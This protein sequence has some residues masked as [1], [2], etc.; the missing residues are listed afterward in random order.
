MRSRELGEIEMRRRPGSEQ[1]FNLIEII[2]ALAVVA[3]AIAIAFPMFNSAPQNLGAD[4]QDFSL[5]V[6]VARE[7]GTSR[8]EHYRVRVFSGAPYQYAIEGCTNFNGTNCIAWA[9][10]RVI[11]LRPN[12]AFDAGTL[13][14]VAEF[15]TRGMLVTTPPVTFTLQDTARG[16][17][18]QVT[19]N[20]V[21]MVDRP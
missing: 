11:G 1:G 3:A 21:G 12:V 15:D 14:L 9:T 19:V 17:S 18:K 6:Q 16:W 8:T 10:E 13:G 4:L 7:L 2:V 5:N 20:A